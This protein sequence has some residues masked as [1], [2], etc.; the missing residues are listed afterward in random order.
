VRR[1]AL[2]VLLGLVLAASGLASVEV[3]AARGGGAACRVA[4]LPGA[5]A[6]RVRARPGARYAFST[7]AVD[8]AGNR[9]AAPARPDAVTR[10]LKPPRRRR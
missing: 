7:I 1:I 10:V 8:R 5:G 4:T 9:E 2:G 6:V 3:Y